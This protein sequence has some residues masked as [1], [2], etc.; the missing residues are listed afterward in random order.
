MV[1]KLNVNIP[2]LLILPVRS[3]V[4]TEEAKNTQKW[5]LLESINRDKQP[6]LVIL[7]FFSIDTAYE[8]SLI[9]T[10]TFDLSKQI[11]DLRPD[12]TWPM[13]LLYMV[14]ST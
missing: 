10:S 6:N 13:I 12:W 4:A 8:E 9:A 3:G 11:G 7:K 14:L 2:A 5:L 1:V